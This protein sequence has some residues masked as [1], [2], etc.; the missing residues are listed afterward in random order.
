MHNKAMQVLLCLGCT[1]GVNFSQLFAPKP[2]TVD[3]RSFGSLSQYGVQTVRFAQD[4]DA[5]H[6]MRPI[7]DAFDALARG[8][9]TRRRPKHRHA[10]KTHHFSC[11][12]WSGRVLKH[13]PGNSQAAALRPEEAPPPEGTSL[14]AD[15]GHAFHC[16]AAGTTRAM[17]WRVDARIF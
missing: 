12:A 7:A 14:P 5:K 16:Y 15:A 11:A 3:L 17:R 13:R 4:A 1:T 8:N 10:F 2:P 9:A 6:I